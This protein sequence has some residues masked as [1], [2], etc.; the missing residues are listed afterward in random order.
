MVKRPNSQT[1][2]Q[3]KNANLA[4][5]NQADMGAELIKLVMPS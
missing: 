1:V 5:A 3:S 2:K 4:R